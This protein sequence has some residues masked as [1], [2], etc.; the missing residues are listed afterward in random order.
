MKKIYLFTLI[1]TSLT[2]YG[3]AQSVTL[4]SKSG[5]LAQN[6]TLIQ[7]GTPDSSELITFVNVKNITTDPVNIFCKK[8]DLSM[9]DST[10]STMCWAGGCYPSWVTV[11]NSPQTIGAGETVTDFSGHYVWTGKKLGFR[12][13][14]SVIRWV[15]YNA[16]NITDSVSLTVYYTTYGAGLNEA[17]I[18]PTALSN[19]YPNPANSQVTIGYSVPAGTD[20]TIV[21]RDVLGSAKKTVRLDAAS[22]KV[23]INT[24]DLSSG[25]YFYSLEVNG[26]TAQTKK[27][28]VRH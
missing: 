23:S 21:I 4:I 26:K 10:E 24:S 11:S 2:F 19:G 27:L 3:I 6:T 18:G 17:G 25:I 8:S 28:V 13:G 22:G 1:L 5:I 9:M 16:I 14:E 20:G 15:F 7:A 12:T